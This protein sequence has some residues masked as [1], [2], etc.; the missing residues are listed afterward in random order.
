M[1][2]LVIFI[3]L[4]VFSSN[5][6]K[7]THFAAADIWYE[8]ISPLTYKVH[9]ASY[10]DCCTN[11]ANYHIS[12]FC[13]S[14]VNAGVS[15]SSTI[16]TSDTIGTN[17][18]FQ[19]DTLD[20]LCAGIPNYCASSSS[21]YPA[22]HYR[23]FIKIVVLP[24]AQTDWRF[25]AQDNARN[26][27]INNGF[28]N[29]TI[30]VYAELNNL[31]RPIN[32]SPAFT[33]KPIPY[34]CNNQPQVYQNGPLDPD[35]DSVVTI[36]NTPNGGACGLTSPLTFSA[37]FSLA[38]PFPTAVPG[39]NVSATTGSASFTPTT[40]GIYVVGF[41]SNDY[42][43]VTGVKVG[44]SMR[45]V[46]LVVLACNN[47]PP[48]S[49]TLFGIVGAIDTVIAGQHVMTVCPGTTMSFSALG[50]VDTSLAFNTIVSYANNN[51]ISP[52]SPSSYTTFYPGGTDSIIGTF[53]W[54]PTALDYGQWTLIISFVDSTC[55]V[56]QPIVLK[57][58]ETIVINVL[59]GVS[60]GGPY[61]Y[62]PGASPLQLSA[63]GP[64]GITSWTW[65]T[66][67]GQGPVQANISNLNIANPI[68]IPSATVDV[69]VEGLPIVTGC[70]NKD[71]V[72]LYV[73]PA[74]I[75]NA[76]PDLTPCANDAIT[77]NASFNRPPINTA[78]FSNPQLWSTKNYMTSGQYTSTPSLTPLGSETYIY[79][80][81][82]SYGCIA[83]D[84]VNVIVQG[85]RPIINAYPAKDPVCIG[86]PVKLY[87]NASPQPCGISANA[88]VGVATNKTVGTGSVSNSFFSPFYRDYNDA[89]RAQYLVKASELIA[90]GLSPGNI[91]GL[92]VNVL[93]APSNALS[94][95]LVNF[96][97]KLG[98]TPVSDLSATVGFQSGMSNVLSLPKYSPTLGNNVFSFPISSEYFWDGKSNLIVEFCYNLTNTFSGGQPAIVNSVATPFNSAL[99][100][101]SNGVGTGCSLPGNAPFGNAAATSLRPNFKFLFVKT[102]LFTYNWTPAA[103]FTSPTDENPNVKPGYIQNNSTFQVTVISG[104]TGQCNG[105]A[106]VSVN[107]DNSGAVDAKA[108]PNH[109]C[110]QGLTTL[111]ATPSP[112]TTP[113]V[114]TCGEE[115]FVVNAPPINYTIGAGA[116]TNNFPYNGA[117]GAKTQYI[118]LASELT[119]AGITKGNISELALNVT[120]KNSFAPFYDF[121]IYLSCTKDNAITNFINASNR[122]HVFNVATLNTSI[123][124]N[125]YVFN[126]GTFVWDGISNIAV[127]ICYGNSANGTFNGDYVASSLTT[128]NSNYCENTYNASGCDLGSSASGNSYTNLLTY[129]PN[130]RLKVSGVADKAFQY[131]WNP[132][133]YVYDTASAQTIAYVLNSKTYTVSLVNK[134]GC[135]ISD[136]V[137][138][139]IETHDVTIS[140]KDTQM[141]S[142][143]KI[144]ITAF[145]SGT[146]KLPTY[147]WLPNLNLTQL[148]DTAVIASP[149]TTT[150]YMVIRTDEFGCK[151]TAT[152]KLKVLPDPIVTIL[153]GDTLLV[154][155]ENEVNLLANGAYVYSWTPTWGLSNA[156]SNSTFITPT[157]DGLYYVYGIDTNGCGN[158][159]TIYIKINNTNPVFIPTA[160]SPNR[161]GYNDVFKIQNY[162]FEKIQEF[163]VFN[164]LGEEVYSGKD[165]SGWT[166]TYRGKPC[167]MDTYMYIIRMAY[168]DGSVKVYKGDVL[169]MR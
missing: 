33:V 29:T 75:V 52:N 23:H 1:K 84:T 67:P 69:V 17:D 58:Y 20:Q 68:A 35:L 16:V 90:A 66:I 88:G 121:N 40:N 85:I 44:S 127:E 151:D 106:N 118:L 61:N 160:F 122:K 65:S 110:D 19:D 132:P 130:T 155:Y 113:P 134:T 2:N 10:I 105:T 162:K 59:P 99:V 148:A 49:D 45:D 74:L 11:C 131:V 92:T 70:P 79:T 138:V 144:Q 111:S 26:S 114:F 103:A 57:S 42:D 22:F 54:T 53:S 63:S 43:R 129:R 27:T 133:L 93:S 14:S 4:I 89:Y 62:C 167:D 157:Q 165:N 81:K 76:G 128:F 21:I 152:M 108:T 101:Q 50:R 116:T 6:V 97:I 102:N 107:I 37:P 72:T 41:Q 82:D 94:D 9:I 158:Y 146:G 91:K 98:C 145:G 73:W 51:I 163:R 137:Q 126:K 104:A 150:N 159:D 95:T 47:P 24:S 7:A 78:P 60:A 80:V 64:A 34:V 56:G 36:A 3:L 168:P 143:D 71:T 83:K 125:T 139:R 31:A 169:L 13:Y 141:C 161:D 135:L 147:Q 149:P 55:A 166:G 115:N 136:T 48:I 142:D 156:N 120:G 12:N 96:K 15:V 86:E 123:G 140:P 77:I 32:S 119:A 28:S 38:N 153:N 30:S 100:D 124:W 109:L 8:Y 18:P 39:Y 112:G 154:P 117:P 46:Q 87:A 164:R 5:K 25:G